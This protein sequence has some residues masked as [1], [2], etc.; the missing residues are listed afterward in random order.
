MAAGPRESLAPGADSSAIEA[1]LTD[2]A[3]TGR[4]LEVILVLRGRVRRS[5]TSERLRWRMRVDG[6]YVVTFRADAVV[7][8]T[9]AVAPRRGR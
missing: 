9:P 4:P 6:R 7:A 5:G 1:R 3:E 8:A 2:A